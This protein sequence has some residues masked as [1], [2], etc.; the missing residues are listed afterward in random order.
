MAFWKGAGAESKTG[1]QLFREIVES[2]GTMVIAV[3]PD[4]TILHVNPAAERLLG[5]N[6]SELVG[7]KRTDEI[8]APEEAQRVLGEVQRLIGSPVQGS[9][10]QR[11]LAIDERAAAA[12]Q[13]MDLLPPSQVPSF[14]ARCTRK[15]GT[16]FP[17]IG[18][19]SAL[20]D[21]SGAIRGLVAVALDQTATLRQQQAARES[22][23]RYRDLFENSDEMIATLSPSGHFVYANP[24]W[25]RSFGLEP[26]ALLKL[27]SFE[28]VFS[29]D[30]REEVAE[31]F[32][33]ALHGTTVER[34]MLRNPTEDGQVLELELSLSRRQ[35]ADNPL[36]VRCLLRNVTQQKQREHRLALQLAASQ[37]VSENSS[38]DAAAERILEALCTT[39]GWD[40]GVLWEIDEAESRP[41]FSSA[42]GTPGL[43]TESMMRQR[44]GAQA[45]AGNTL[46]GCAWRKGRA[47]WI[48]DLA[49]A[50]TN[51]QPDPLTEGALRCGMAS[52]WA[53]PVRAGS[54]IVAV[55]EFYSRLRLREDS[56]AL[57]SVETVAAPLGQMLARRREHGRT[58]ELSRRQEILLN[59][60]A[61]GICGLDRVGSVTFAN[62]AAERLLG[63][64]AVS[65]EGRPMHD[66]LH[67]RD[68]C[69][70]ECPLRM[71]LKSAEDR[72]GE[73][74]IFRSDETSLPIEYGFT[75]IFD[76]GQFSG[77]VLS[78][79]DISQRYALDR[80]K[81]EFV[82]TAGHELRTP[83]TS[84]RGALGLLS[85]G[86]LGQMDEKAASLLRIALKNSERLIRL[87]N[88]ILDLER[89][90]Y[91]RG[92]ETF[93]AVQLARIVDEAIRGVQTVAD[94]TG[95]QLIHDTMQ[96]Q[97][98]G[99]ADQLLQ[100]MTNLL[101]NA[102]KFSPSGATVSVMMRSGEDGATI[103]VIDQGRGIPVE[104]LET[105]FGR[106][107]QVDASDARQKGG[108]GLGLAICRT[109]VTQHGGRI[110]AERNPVR[111]STFRV[112]LPFRRENAAGDEEPVTARHNIVAAHHNI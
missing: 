34:A 59:A 98:D 8:I 43:H 86:A 20:R 25:K 107:T 97:V 58:E 57:D 2:A 37:I 1:D 45:E 38:V 12:V 39:H 5:Y 18:H 24:A 76:R 22:Q 51:S 80:M 109:I 30:C 32:Q 95:I 74:T 93:E 65:V 78:F 7:Q 89:I 21:S 92:P 64:S 19:I 69:G 96:A 31:L 61:D 29:P 27:D 35:K 26:A 68:E 94:A 50:Q 6:A 87:V 72:T 70:P 17:V 103:S 47:L 56:D 53:V 52:G 11:N 49:E 82:A 90:Q 36:A 106:F 112:Y 67:P 13:A 85:S 54:S 42:W 66:L 88:D 3:G 111:G 46:A 4:G 108:S 55:L 84:I 77:S 100:V 33:E 99:D 9:P 83:L 44:L 40:F 104:M 10:A 110:W 101:S 79:R 48:R 60:V 81:D 71:A 16:T 91:G 73:T 41:V 62:P 14:E 23:E 28:Q 75:P 105:I 15:D 63:A 102:I